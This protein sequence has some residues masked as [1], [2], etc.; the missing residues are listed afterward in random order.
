MY[1]STSH[2][3]FLNHTITGLFATV[4]AGKA[5]IN[6]YRKEYYRIPCLHTLASSIKKWYLIFIVALYNIC[7]T[8]PHTV[9]ALCIV[10]A[11]GG[12]ALISV[13]K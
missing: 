12:I 11:F 13:G 4:L 5:C 2:I 6:R 9:I 3:L 8:N 1:V 10:F 7:F